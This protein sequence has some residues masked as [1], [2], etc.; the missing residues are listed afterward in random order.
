[1]VRFR[2][3]RPTLHWNPRMLKVRPGL[4]PLK[5]LQRDRILHNITTYYNQWKVVRS[6]RD[7]ELGASR[8]SADFLWG[9]LASL[10]GS[11]NPCRDVPWSRSA[12][13]APAR[14][15]GWR[16]SAWCWARDSF[17]RCRGRFPRAPASSMIPRRQDLGRLGATGMIDPDNTPCFVPCERPFFGPFLL[18]WPWRHR[19]LSEMSIDVYTFKFC[20][21]SM[22]FLYGTR[23]NSAFGGSNFQNTNRPCDPLWLYVLI[24]SLIGAFSPSIQYLSSWFSALGYHSNSRICSVI[25]S[26]IKLNITP[27]FSKGFQ[28]S[29]GRFRGA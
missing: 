18:F 19:G 23:M 17:R 5:H 29:L 21:L 15:C 14:R 9:D 2:M 6:T 8:P 24:F 7:L 4:V 1:M 20:G 16:R 13:S 10:L 22:E 12:P 25:P 3:A 11:C 28:P 26:P 27:W